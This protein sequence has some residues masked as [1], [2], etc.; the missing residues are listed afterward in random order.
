MNV[1]LICQQ[2][3]REIDNVSHIYISQDN[4]FQRKTSGSREFINP[5]YSFLV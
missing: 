5:K 3:N 4:I 1:A 2:A